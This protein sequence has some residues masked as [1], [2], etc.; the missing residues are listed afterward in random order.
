[1]ISN[2]TIFILNLCFSQVILLYTKRVLFFSRT[3]L[4]IKALRRSIYILCLYYEANLMTTLQIPLALSFSYT[5]KNIKHLYQTHR[6]K[7]IKQKYNFIY[8]TQDKPSFHDPK[9]NQIVW[10]ISKRDQNQQ[11]CSYELS[12][13]GTIRNVLAS[14]LIRHYSLNPKSFVNIHIYIY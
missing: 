11:K 10:L 5:G 12:C 6:E 2:Y 8:W 13:V 7:K 4:H 1:M 14:L 3:W 9:C